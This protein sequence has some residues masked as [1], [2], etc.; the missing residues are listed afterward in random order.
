MNL[1]NN[2]FVLMAAPLAVFACSGEPAPPADGHL[3]SA[4]G[5][6]ASQGSTQSESEP[7]PSSDAGASLDAGEQ[8]PAPDAAP[9]PKRWQVEFTKL[10]VSSNGKKLSNGEDIT[11]AFDDIV[12]LASASAPDP[13]PVD[14]GVSETFNAK[15]GSNHEMSTTSRLSPLA[16]GKCAPSAPRPWFALSCSGCSYAHPRARA[17]S[18]RG[19]QVPPGPRR[20][21][22]SSQARAGPRAALLGKSGAAHPEWR[23]PHPAVP[24]RGTPRRERRTT[25]RR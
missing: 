14:A 23:P 24:W 17:R 18:R 11:V 2:V 1:L 20:A 19:A 5:T 16:T 7:E 25:P 9:P 10:H 15:D 3:S 21:H 8:V 12:V 4:R 6:D 22:R 13:A